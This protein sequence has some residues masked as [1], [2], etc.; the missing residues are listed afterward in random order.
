MK[1]RNCLENPAC[2]FC[3][4]AVEDIRVFKGT[5][6]VLVMDWQDCIGEGAK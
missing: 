5:L 1:R 4:L 3:G 6:M 2:C